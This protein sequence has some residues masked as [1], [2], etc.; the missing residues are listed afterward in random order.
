MAPL[1]GYVLSGGRGGEIWALFAIVAVIVFVP[2][3]AFYNHWRVR[4]GFE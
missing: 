3:L 4:N 1:L 2:P